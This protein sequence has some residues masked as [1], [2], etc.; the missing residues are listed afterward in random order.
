MVNV[1]HDLANSHLDY[2]L[3]LLDG[4]LQRLGKYL[5]DYHLSNPAH[6]WNQNVINP[7]IAD[8]LEYNPM[9]EN[10]QFK[11]QYNQ[12]NLDQKICFD[13][14]TRDIVEYPESAQFFV[15]KPAST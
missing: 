3:F 9:Q 1:P 13:T 11:Q 5:Q 14:I 2:G 8:Q 15:Q 6:D 10:N 4:V 12:L 7:I